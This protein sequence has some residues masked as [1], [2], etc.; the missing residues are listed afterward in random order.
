MKLLVKLRRSPKPPA[1]TAEA[2]AKA[3]LNAQEKAAK[4]NEQRARLQ[5]KAKALKPR[6]LSAEK[7]VS[8]T[9]AAKDKCA[10][11][12]DAEVAKLEKMLAEKKLKRK[13]ALDKQQEKVDK[14]KN[15]LGGLRMQM[16]AMTKKIEELK[17][18]G[19][20]GDGSVGGTGG[21]GTGGGSKKSNWHSL[22]NGIETPKKLEHMF[23]A[24]QS[25]FGSNEPK[26]RIKPGSAVKI[27]NEA[28]MR[29]F[30]KFST[31]VLQR[32][33]PQGQSHPSPFG[34][35]CD[36]FLFHGSSS[37]NMG[38]ISSE[39]LRSTMPAAHGTMLGN[40]VY[41]APDPRKSWQYCGGTLGNFMIVCRFAAPQA[42]F[43]KNL[44]YDEFCVPN[45]AMCVPLWQVKVE[46][47]V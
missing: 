29:N 26:L 36:T 14:S 24:R 9:V 42:F 46:R 40:G 5:E 2:K 27:E 20:G 6:L 1:L 37:G 33:P 45:E 13:S 39:G 34:Q 44:I 32:D 18:R 35:F 21:G 17:P 12:L 11:G 38:N 23:A 43:K 10:K 7:A 8:V 25:T 28:L 3:K 47:T 4:K 16:F 41:G 15:K 22:A 19:G 30:M 31:G